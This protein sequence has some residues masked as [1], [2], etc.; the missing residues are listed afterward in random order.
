[1]PLDLSAFELALA[2]LPAFAA[3][4]LALLQPLQQRGASD[5]A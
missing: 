1:M 5:G 3:D 4:A 2:S